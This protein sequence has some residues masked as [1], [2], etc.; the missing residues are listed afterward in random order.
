MKTSA[1]GIAFLKLREGFRS[2]VYNDTGGVATIGYGHMVLPGEKFDSLS[3][4]E[5]TALL[6]KDINIAESCVNNFVKVQLNQNQ[7]DALISFI[8]NLGCSAFK[9]STLLRLLNAG[10]YEGAANQFQRWSN[11]NGKFV[12]ALLKRRMLEKQL[13]ITKE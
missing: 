6:Y 1:K 11:D 13:F 2:K 7:F 10:D 12:S 4:Q 5:A 9:G 3:I 8:Y